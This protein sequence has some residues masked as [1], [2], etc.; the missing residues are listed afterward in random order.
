MGHAGEQINK[1]AR[2]DASELASTQT[3]K[4]VGKQAE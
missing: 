3:N 2:N 1:T 4:Q